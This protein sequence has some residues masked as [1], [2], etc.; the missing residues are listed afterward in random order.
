M[1]RRTSSTQRRFGCNSHSGAVGPRVPFLRKGQV[2]AALL[3][4]L[5][6]AIAVG[7]S[8]SSSVNATGDSAERNDTPAA[9]AAR[10]AELVL[11]TPASDEAAL[12]GTTS[13]TLNPNGTEM[14]SS[15]T[16]P[17]AP[18]SGEPIAGVPARSSPNVNAVLSA[19][20][21]LANQLS[22]PGPVALVRA[23]LL[24]TV[25][26]WSHAGATLSPSPS[27]PSAP[28]VHR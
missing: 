1:H 2:L 25:S 5:A 27:A 20:R 10:E 12:V 19:M 11:T 21:T 23:A 8:G 4:V 3:G 9:S 7:V 28:P 22:G 13:S 16:V 14:P 26:A 18:R 15:V 24:N 6:V 17:L